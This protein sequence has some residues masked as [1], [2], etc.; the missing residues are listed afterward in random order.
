MLN[1]HTPQ[2]TRL[3]YMIP[4]V[5]DLQE[6]NWAHP[7]H[8]VHLGPPP[9]PGLMKAG[10]PWMSTRKGNLPYKERFEKVRIISNKLGAE[11]F[12]ILRTK[13]ID[14]VITPRPSYKAL[15]L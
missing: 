13:L 2:E 12:C 6:N 5:L 14:S 11:K 8:K 3:T 15:C 4:G 10:V 9:P 1:T 7:G